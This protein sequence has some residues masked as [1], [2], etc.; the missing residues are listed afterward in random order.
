MSLL[1]GGRQDFIVDC[2]LFKHDDFGSAEL[3][4]GW[5]VGALLS[6]LIIIYSA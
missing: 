3:L 6:V 4:F 2:P 5:L 1:S